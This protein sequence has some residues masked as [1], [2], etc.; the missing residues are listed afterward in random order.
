MTI[1]GVQVLISVG[2]SF[3]RKFIIEGN[4]YDTEQLNKYISGFAV[5]DT[6]VEQWS[7]SDNLNYSSVRYFQDNC[8]IIKKVFM[9]SICEKDID[10][11][12]TKSINVLTISN[13]FTKIEK[14]YLID[15]KEQFLKRIKFNWAF[16]ENEHVEEISSS[17]GVR[18]TISKKFGKTISITKVTNSEQNTE[19]LTMKYMG[20]EIKEYKKPRTIIILRSNKIHCVVLRYYFV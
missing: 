3:W 17:K 20:Q 14:G 5:T 15:G 16:K 12:I 9:I 13:I 7:Y 2:D 19:I 8:L 11:A 1:N 10:C 18:K 4:I 6:N